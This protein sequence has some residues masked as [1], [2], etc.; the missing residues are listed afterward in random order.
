MGK[1]KIRPQARNA[2]KHTLQG[3]K[4]LERSMQQRGYTESMVAAAD[5]EVFIGSARLETTET[6]FKGVEP[7]IIESDGTRP[8]IH[9][10]TDIPNADDPRAVVL[11]LESNEIHFE[12]YDPDGDVLAAIAREDASVLEV[13]SRDRLAELLPQA[14]PVEDA[15]AQVDRAEELREKWGVLSGDLWQIREHRVICGDCTD[16]AVVARV[17]GGERARL[18][19]TSPPYW[20][21]REYENEKG[22]S[23]IHA[24]ID[25]AV[26]SFVSCVMDKA[27]I[28]INTGT[29][30]ETQNGGNVRRVWLLLDWWAESFLRHGWNMRNVRIWRKEG[31]FSSFSPEQDL[32]GMNWEFIASFT[33]DKP[34]KQN[35]VGERWALDGV[36]DCQPDSGRGPHTA[37]FPLEIPERFLKLY[38]Q[39][40]E[41][42]FE[43]YCGSGTTL[44][45]C[46]RLHRRGRGIE[47]SPA[48]V[49]VTLERMAALGLTPQLLERAA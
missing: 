26:Q 22:R 45:A 39:E 20:I 14:E 46:E 44:V 6:V 13:F 31:G 34:L 8:I 41:F 7:I 35:K 36:W 40:K 47:L 21:G 17:M 32:C 5:G 42:V 38:T 33:P 18:V 49:A 43:P 48:Y 24:H 30:T 23:E 29:S 27:H 37:P 11:G 9:I 28:A 10:R 19:V 12:N 25:N 3:M 15:G 4:K 1:R 2:N 16:A